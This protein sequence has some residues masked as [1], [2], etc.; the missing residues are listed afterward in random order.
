VVKTYRSSYGRD[1]V[2]FS[3]VELQLLEF[4]GSL[5]ASMDTYCYVHIKKL[6]FKK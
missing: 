6:T 1:Q 2:L 5:L 3:V 4:N